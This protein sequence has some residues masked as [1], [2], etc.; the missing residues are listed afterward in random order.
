MQQEQP[1][2]QALPDVELLVVELAEQA[3]VADE[4]AEQEFFVE[5]E[6]SCL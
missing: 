4:L 3:S 2:E 1:V 5:Y 6:R